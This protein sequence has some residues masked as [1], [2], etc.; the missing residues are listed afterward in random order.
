M[1]KINNPVTVTLDVEDV[2]HIILEL[3]YNIGQYEDCK[4]DKR[5]EQVIEELE[6]A[7][8]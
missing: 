7:K 4:K 2:E 8:E 6:R 1:L 3:S 5:I